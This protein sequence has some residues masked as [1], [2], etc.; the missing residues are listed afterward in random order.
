[1]T[2]THTTWFQHLCRTV[3]FLFTLATFHPASLRLP[4]TLYFAHWTF[5]FG[6][7]SAYGKTQDP[8]PVAH[9]GASTSKVTKPNLSGLPASLVRLPGH[10]LPALAKA[11][12]VAP[13]SQAAA[14]E[15]LTLTL[16]L[17]RDDQ[18]GFERYLHDVYDPSFAN[19]RHFLTQSEL[20]D[21][22]G[23]SRDA[24]DGV[25]SYLQQNGF[26]LVEGSA[27]RLTLTVRGTRA[28][29]ERALEVYIGD[30]ELAE[31]R[32][33]AN[34]RDPALPAQLAARVQ[35][36]AGLSNLA[37]PQA[38]GKVRLRRRRSPVGWSLR[39]W[40]SSE[41]SPRDCGCS[42]ASCPSRAF[43]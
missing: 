14:D 40:P 39:G 18:A 21:R 41:S 16:V 38:V 36:I 31:R 29:T 33:Y 24:Y 8:L 3:L 42:G 27:N 20:S 35:A 34:E 5:D 32:F 11:K 7:T 15:P 26:T 13:Q 4:W 12:A 1:M 30:Y 28:Q 43:S 10:V 19:Y 9:P 23:P 6:P 22:F 37:E 17:K 25:L 2:Y